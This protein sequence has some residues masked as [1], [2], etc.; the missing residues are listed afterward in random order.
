M[1]SP[2]IF[3]AANVSVAVLPQSKVSSLMIRPRVPMM[4]KTN[5]LNLIAS[6]ID[7]PP[8]PALI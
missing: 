3:A 4:S 5:A 2:T 8:I 6:L 7:I 1:A